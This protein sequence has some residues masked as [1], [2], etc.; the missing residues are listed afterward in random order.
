MLDQILQQTVVPSRLSNARG[1]SRSEIGADHNDELCT[2]L[3]HAH[4]LEKYFVPID[5]IMTTTNTSTEISTK[6]NAY[7]HIH[8]RPVTIAV[9]A[10]LIRIKSIAHTDYG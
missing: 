4:I 9:E 7:Q 3:Y 10:A 5:I 6:D 1:L 8:F 2:F